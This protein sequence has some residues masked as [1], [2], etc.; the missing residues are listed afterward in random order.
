MEALVQ[1]Y[2]LGKGVNFKNLGRFINKDILQKSN[3]WAS[4]LE[5]TPSAD[6]GEIKPLWRNND[7]F[8][9]SFNY[10]A[11]TKIRNFFYVRPSDFAV[12][13]RSLVLLTISRPLLLS[14]HPMRLSN[15]MSLLIHPQVCLDLEHTSKSANWTLK[16]Y[17]FTHIHMYLQRRKKLKQIHINSTLPVS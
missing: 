15:Y 17:C 7:S 8:D 4:F 11:G 3:K 13:S 1:F 14:E 5:R 10:K 9:A 2:K 12:F 16:Y 6:I